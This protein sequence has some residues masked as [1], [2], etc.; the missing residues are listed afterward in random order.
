MSVL[1][2]PTVKDVVDYL[3]T[4]PPDCKFEMRDADTYWVVRIVHCDYE[5]EL[6]T[7]TLFGEYGEMS[8]D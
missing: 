3:T 6:N 4:L 7:V 8:H 2:T 1:N 5:P